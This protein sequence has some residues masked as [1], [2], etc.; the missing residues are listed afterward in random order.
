MAL[1]LAT[2]DMGSNGGLFGKLEG[3]AGLLNVDEDLIHSGSVLFY[4]N[5][6][7][8]RRGNTNHYLLLYV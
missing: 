3:I 7:P 4:S 8:G 1:P 2:G 5:K 6:S